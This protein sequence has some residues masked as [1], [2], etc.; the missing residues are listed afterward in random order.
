MAEI[1]CQIYCLVACMMC[2]QCMGTVGNFFPTILNSLGYNTT[3]TLLL[4]APPYSTSERSSY[5]DH[6]AAHVV[7]AG[8]LT[9]SRS[10]RLLRVL[11]SHRLLGRTYFATFARLVTRP[12]DQVPAQGR[13]LLAA[14]DL[15]VHRH[16]SVHHRPVDAQHGRTILCNDVHGDLERS[17]RT[18]I[19]TQPV[20]CQSGPDVPPC[21]ILDLVTLHILFTQ[22]IDVAPGAALIRRSRPPVVPLQ[23]HVA[24]HRPTLPQARGRTRSDERHRGHVQRVGQLRVG[25]GSEASV[26]ALVLNGQH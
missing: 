8:P 21:Q 25:L 14:H 6:G 5:M 22:S 20:L 4:T 17:V 24:P 26:S 12:A 11:R 18:S 15:P 2:S 9:Q 3:I 19:S 23:H 7:N 13:V 10:L 16:R 1:P